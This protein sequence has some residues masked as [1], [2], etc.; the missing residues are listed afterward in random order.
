MPTRL[1]P[2]RPSGPTLG[3]GQF[4]TPW[5]RM[6]WLNL[7]SSL[8]M[9]CKAAWVVR[10]PFGSRCAQLPS[11]ARYREPLTPSCCAPG[12]FVVVWPRWGSGKFATPLA[13]MQ[14]ENASNWEFADSRAVDE[15]PTTADD[16][17]PPSHADTSRATPTVAMIPTAIRAV[18]GHARCGLC[19]TRL[20]FMTPSSIGTPSVAPVPRLTL[21]IGQSSVNAQD[22]AAILGGILQSSCRLAVR[23][24]E[25]TNW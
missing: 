8:S 20:P 18:G 11:A 5:A 16:P 4:G 14:R 12:N 22:R 21:K 24:W 19:M 17:L 1:K 3:S 6:H 2:G 23:R 15:P 13:R 7:T 25:Q 10:P 9:C